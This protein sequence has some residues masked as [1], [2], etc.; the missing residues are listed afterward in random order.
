MFLINSSF[1]EWKS[2]AEGDGGGKLDLDGFTESRQSH[3]IRVIGL[4]WSLVGIGKLSKQA[5]TLINVSYLSPLA[6]CK[7]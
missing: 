1:E 7:H 2:F 5:G 3:A 6:R 4:D